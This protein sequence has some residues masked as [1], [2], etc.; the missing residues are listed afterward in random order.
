LNT[1]FFENQKELTFVSF[2]TNFMRPIMTD[3][4][5]IIYL[6]LILFCSCHR[7]EKIP[8]EIDVRFHIK[9]ENYTSP[10]KVSIENNTRG[11]LEYQWYFEGGEPSSST[12]S[13]P[14]IISFSS[15]GEHSIRLEARNEGTMESQVFQL[16]VDS[17][18]EASFVAEA[19]INNYAPALFHINNLSRGGTTYKWIFEGG[20]PSV[21]EGFAPPAVKYSNEGKYSITL[22][23]WNGSATFTDTRAIEVRQP[24]DASFSIVPSFED[25]DDMEAPL[26]ATF[27]VSLQGVETLL[28]TY[29]GGEITNPDSSDAEIYIPKAG[30]YIVNLQVSNGKETKMVSQEITVK[31]NSNLR[32]HEN[33]ELGINSAHADYAVFYST[34]LR[35]AFKVSEVNAS[36]G[37]MIDIVFFGL[38]ANFTYNKFVSPARLSETTFQE[39]PS[40]THTRFINKTE[41]GSLGFSAAQFTSI[42][43]DAL[44][45]NI[46][47][48]SVSYGNEPFTSSPLPRVVLFETSDG[49]KGAILVKEMVA[50]GREDS[51]IRIDIKVQKND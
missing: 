5:F 33:I 1:L 39:I 30:K 48:S 44:L 51:Y 25:E 3:R 9:D 2:L 49:R 17:A 42:S 12:E 20:E 19:E 22:T 38:S 26:R 50:N 31:E 7:E 29:E 24:L 41:L 45:R 10:L 15:P 43:T 13:T 23:I 11:A 27:N 16:R 14:G 40:A 35:R 37:S 36:N 21:Y 6:L 28:W 47:I 34:K 4:L 46:S 32:I 18:V 8:I